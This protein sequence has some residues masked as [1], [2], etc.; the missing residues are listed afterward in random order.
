MNK[1]IDI[2]TGKIVSDLH[3]NSLDNKTNFTFNVD[4]VYETLEKNS[5]ET[6]LSWLKLQQGWCNNAY[7]TFKDY[8]SY[9]ILVY[10]ILQIMKKYSDR[11]QFLSEDQFY[12]KK[13]LQLEKINLIEISK[14]LNI[15]KETI[16]RKIIFLQKEGVLYR[17]GKSIF[18]NAT[19]EQF[20]RPVVS[21]PLLSQFLEKHSN[22]LSK[23][24]WFGEHISKEKIEKFLTDYFTIGWQHWLRLQV[25]YLVNNRSFFGD[26]ETW[27]VWGSIGISQFHDYSRQIEQSLIEKPA[28]YKDL[29]ITLLNHTP[30]VGINASS[31]AEISQIPRATVIRKLKHL[32]RQKLVK[33][34]KK[35]EYIFQKTSKQNEFL[36]GNYKQ[37]K[38]YVSKFVHTIFDLMKFS[39]LNN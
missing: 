3:D 2:N 21:K 5:N 15:P 11:F 29:Y 8:D 32:V 19:I 27:N 38:L 22:I 28:N 31:I 9:L 39:K 36:E 7:K 6:F 14:D 30:N 35:L 4:E 13:D 16:R 1:P 10:L 34:N 37:N 20:Q 23:E 24:K 33:R 12:N 26:L 18:F 25:P 17:K